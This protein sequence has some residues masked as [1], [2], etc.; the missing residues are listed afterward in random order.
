MSRPD[1][2]AA[3]TI[4]ASHAPRPLAAKPRSMSPSNISLYV[5]NLRLLNLDQRQDWPEITV[6][7]FDT[8]DALQN[9]KKR[10]SCVEWSL[11]RLFEIW[12]RE[13]TRERLQPF[14]P[15]L[16]PI[17][18]LNLRAALF[19]CLNDLKKNDVLGRE[20]TLRKTMLDDC[21]GDKFEEV[22]LLFSAAVVRKQVL[23][24]RRKQ[25]L[26][27]GKHLALAKQLDKQDLLTF[28][29]LSL[30]YRVS[31]T[32]K[33][34]SRI[35]LDSTIDTFRTSLYEKTN[36]YHQLHLTLLET[37]DFS[38]GA[39]SQDTEKSI[40]R[41]LRQNWIG[42]VEGCDALLAGANVAS[43]D[44]YMDST[45]EDLWQHFQQGTSPQV[46]P[47]NVSL[48]E[49]LR[50]RVVE[51]NERLRLWKMYKDVFEGSN[52]AV[53]PARKLAVSS[54]QDPTAAAY[55]LD[56]FNKHK[57]VSVEQIPAENTTDISRID[58]MVDY[59][60][61]VQDMK[62]CLADVSK[63]KRGQPDGALSHTAP[64]ATDRLRRTDTMPRQLP[65][66]VLLA[67]SK[68]PTEDLFSPLKRPLLESTNSTPIS[69][70]DGPHRPHPFL[71]RTHSQPMSTPQSVRSEHS[72]SFDRSTTISYGSALRQPT[73]TDASPSVQRAQDQCLE[74]DT[75]DHQPGR[76]ETPRYKAS[77]AVPVG[78]D[79][80]ST[81]PQDSDDV[82]ATSLEHRFD[83][84][85]L[86]EQAQPQSPLNLPDFSA[87][88]SSSPPA[89]I[90]RHESPQAR[91]NLSDRARLSMSSFRSSENGC[92]LPQP[93]PGAFTSPPD[94]ESTITQSR[95]TS[96]ADRALA[97]MTQASLH[98][99]PQRAKTTKELPRS[100]FFPLI[101]TQEFSTPIKGGRTSL[102]GTRDTTPRDKLFEQDAEY[103]SVF[104]SRPKIAM[105]PVISPQFEAEMEEAE[106]F[107]FE[108]VDG[109]G[110]ESM[111]RLQSS[112]LGKFG[113]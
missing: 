73:F 74:T 86:D 43:S 42:S 92:P 35:A 82:P 98:P 48:L 40:R 46:P 25:R 65:I 58:L 104:K 94:H 9:Q 96:L 64:T 89:P 53:D 29:P 59:D 5:S 87:S 68:E 52:K 4:N 113:L 12:D 70:R 103:A 81:K 47:E 90:S 16:E 14:F 37:R 97:S 85:D 1:S 11:Y 67:G 93:T 3:S 77:S 57:G 111:L 44:A 31:L 76:E 75:L 100:S 83:A 78:M 80:V 6:R 19:R 51:Q 99:Q 105:S 26:S 66:Q 62:H 27:I 15:P 84:M 2:V 91:P 72:R 110:E 112:P 23:S 95:R 60:Q 33:L 108:G 22:L 13:T 107:S 45:F 17:Q 24:A 102:G 71:P 101:S 20:A 106:D 109:E 79:S 10:V 39:L 63:K 7:T 61:V 18:S 8:K 88:L 69:V 41:E 30:A 21:K 55:G 28:G 36:D 34:H 54:S 49:T 56:I 50:S 38:S 32:K